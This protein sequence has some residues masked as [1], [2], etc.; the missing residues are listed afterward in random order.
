MKNRIKDL[1]ESKKE[2]ILSVFY[3]AGFPTLESTQLIAET[4]AKAGADIIEIGIPYSDPI[5][6]G[7]TIQESNTIALKNGI[8]VS[9]ILDLVKDIRKTVDIPIILMGYVNPV[10]QYGIERFAQDAAAA[11]VDGVILP[12]LPMAAFLDEYKTLFE[13]VNLSNT[14]LI[15]PTTSEDG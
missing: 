10:M 7:P 6:D 13:S 5:A 15:S 4:L 11:G 9:L 2:N 8:R 12:D 1:F 14:F 3:T